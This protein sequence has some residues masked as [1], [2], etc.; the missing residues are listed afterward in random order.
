MVKTPHTNHWAALLVA[1]ALAL[2]ASALALVDTLHV[3]APAAAGGIETIAL[4][5]S[6]KA[7]PVLI[8]VTIKAGWTA[9]QKQAEMMR[10]LDA[11]G[12]FT[13]D[14]TGNRFR[15]ENIYD[16]KWRSG[17]GEPGD[18]MTANGPARGEFE[19][20]L[21]DGSNGPTG[22]DEQGQAAFFQV[23]FFG[24][25]VNAHAQITAGQL[26]QGYGIDDVLSALFNDLLGDLPDPLKAGLVLDLAQD[27]ISFN[28]VGLNVPQ[29]PFEWKVLGGATDTGLDAAIR[30]TS[31]PEPGTWLLL[32]VAGAA[33]L[34]TRRVQAVGASPASAARGCW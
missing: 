21:A 1:A 28:P 25:G 23:G 16:V 32:F 12:H 33:L 34:R 19:L 3:T 30:L 14:L 2:P 5:K 9:D 7:A 11:A 13:T 26:G 6:D 15:V 20:T 24:P 17:T 8:Y 29:G 27:H 31:V 18:D 4:Y 10:V 22:Q